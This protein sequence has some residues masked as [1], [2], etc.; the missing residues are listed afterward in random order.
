HAGGVNLDQHL[1]VRGLRNVDFLEL[2]NF[3]TAE[4]VDADCF[5][6]GHGVAPVRPHCRCRT[7]PR[8]ANQF[9]RISRD[10]HP[11]FPLAPAP[12]PQQTVSNTAR[13]LTQT[14]VHE[15]SSAKRKSLP[16]RYRSRTGQRVRDRAR[17]CATKARTLCR[18][19]SCSR[20]C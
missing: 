20:C 5:H 3:R 17:S 12:P 13:S 8:L 11:I 16:G 1:V 10:S 7:N 15:K 4:R 2:E 19:L 18:T 9:P 14:W 6:F